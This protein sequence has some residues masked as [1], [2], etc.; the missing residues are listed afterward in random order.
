MLLTDNLWRGG[1]GG[2]FKQYLNRPERNVKKHEKLTWK[3]Q[4]K[5]CS[6]TH[7]HFL[8]T[9]SIIAG[10]LFTKNI[11][12]KM[13][14]KKKGGGGG[15]GARKPKSQGVT[16]KPP[17]KRFFLLSMHER[18]KL[19]VRTT[20]RAVLDW[21]TRSWAVLVVLTRWSETGLTTCSQSNGVL[22]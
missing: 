20:D 15:G 19:F 10:G 14:K 5:Y 9:N 21:Y 22:F 13:K 16:F 1:G 17:N 18:Q 8:R 7:L 2:S 12:T 6:N 4:W 11:P 3:F